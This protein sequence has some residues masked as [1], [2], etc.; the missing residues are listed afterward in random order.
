VP[1]T[2]DDQ[3]AAS[4]AERAG[5]LLLGLRAR[6]GDPDRLRDEGD[7]QSHT[8]LVAELARERPADAVLS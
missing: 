7:R 5:Q 8:F 1:P 6:G 3:L 4:L 2:L